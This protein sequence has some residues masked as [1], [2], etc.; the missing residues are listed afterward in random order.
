MTDKEL[1]RIMSRREECRTRLF[2][3]EGLELE[4]SNGRKA[5]FERLLSAGFGAVIIVPLMDNNQ[6]LLVRE[7]AAGLHAYEVG[8][9]KGRLEAGETP[10]QGANRELKEEVGYG[11]RSI[12]EIKA[13]TLAPAYMSHRTR[14]MLAR[15][16]YEE[17]LSGDEPEEIEVVPWS[18]DDIASLAARD[19]VSEARTLA[20]LYLAR[21]FLEQEQQ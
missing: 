12:Q 14:V 7:Y 1:P 19:D 17:K 20:A 10:E 16:L 2:R 13:L 4:F 8:L 15:D 5:G 6:V 9:P 3:V 21:N 11:A 18:L